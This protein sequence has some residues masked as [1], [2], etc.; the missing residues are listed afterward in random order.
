VAALG[1]SAAVW[2]AFRLFGR[3]THEV[4]VRFPQSRP[5]GEPLRIEPGLRA[6]DRFL[7]TV[8]SKARIV[9]ASDY[10]DAG[11]GMKIDARLEVAHDVAA[12][13]AGGLR[14]RLAWKLVD[15]SS[16][17]PG[18]QADLWRVL[19]SADSPLVIERPAGSRALDPASRPQALQIGALELLTSGFADPTLSCLPAG[20][21]VRLGEAWD[22]FD[23][24]AP[25][26]GMERAI[27]AAT[28]TAG[29][30]Y[31]LFVR[32]GAVKAEALETHEGQPVLRLSVLFTVSMQG[33]TRPPAPPG[34][35]SLGGKGEGTVRVSRE[36]GL[37]VTFDLATEF[38]STVEREGRS[39]VER[40]AKQTVS[41]STRRSP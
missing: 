26:E 31:P 39:A 9:L 20:R 38:R 8:E 30:G 16:D 5:T 6:G 15:A 33:D 29:E 28:E 17:I 19:A 37:P 3:A 14:S 35:V 23:E 11:Q 24:V 32:A 25:L 1:L 13:P 18:R 40:A 34:R 27:R 21:D 4:E 2:G 36:T 7:T 10:A 41:A 22:L 12:G